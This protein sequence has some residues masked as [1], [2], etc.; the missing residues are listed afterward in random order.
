MTSL[1]PCSLCVDK[2]THNQSILDPIIT[3]FHAYYQVPKIEEALDSDSDKI[4]NPSNHKM[5]LMIPL[6]S[7]DNKIV[8]EKKTVE[9]RTYGE[10]NYQAMRMQLEE[11]DWG[12][13]AQSIPINKKME[14]FQDSLHKMFQDCFPVKK[15]TFLSHNEPFMNEALLKL[16]RKKSREFRK[17]RRSKKYMDLEALY[18]EM[19][20]M[21][22][23]KFYRRKVRHLRTSKS[24]GWYKSLKELMLSGGKNEKPE[25]EEIKHLSE[26][27]QAEAIADLFAKISNEYKQI[28][29]SN[30]ELPPIV[31][32]DI[33]RIS[34][35]EVKDILKD[36]KLNKAVPK[37]D[38]PAKV[39][40]RFAEY[41]SWPILKMVNPVPKISH[42]QSL[43]DLR[44]ISGLLNISKILEKVVVKYLVKDIKKK[45]NKSQNANQEGQSINHYLVFMIYTILKALDG[46]TLGQHN[47]VIATLC[48]FSKAFDRQDATKAVSQ[49]LSHSSPHKLF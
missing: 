28:N 14:I 24:K 20:S 46:S 9:V 36:L 21:S 40:K 12:F 39:Y 18:K 7:V 44:K 19:I 47:A 29:K 30:I 4:V 35:A 3:D 48:D 17:H 37:N 10:E 34:E 23:K 43:G 41:L 5:V 6:N 49:A 11:F 22:K 1:Q 8:R 2:P 16:K 26:I 38:V 13:I 15:N 27:E 32:E 33:L 45:L 25:R 42:P 31:G